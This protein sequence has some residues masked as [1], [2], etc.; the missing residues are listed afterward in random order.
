MKITRAILIFFVLA[1]CAG[2]A[3]SVR[4][5]RSDGQVVTVSV[6]VADSPM[7]RAR[8]LMYRDRLPEGS[9]MLFLFPF[10]SRDPFWMK[11]TRI[12]LDMI[13]SRHGKIVDII[14][15]ATP[16]SETLRQPKAAYDRVLEVPGGAAE[17]YRVKIGDTMESR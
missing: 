9:G 15:E 4:I 11:N 7:K 14:S 2:A 6:E 3:E 10:E 1:S 12:P 16:Y 17:R 8:G 5:I 13:F